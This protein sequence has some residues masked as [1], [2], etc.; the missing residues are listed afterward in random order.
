V[1]TG[2]STPGTRCTRVPATWQAQQQW[3]DDNGLKACILT[4]KIVWWLPDAVAGA[5][6]AA[7]DDC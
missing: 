3:D 5:A 2:S 7:E 6:A 4:G 1:H